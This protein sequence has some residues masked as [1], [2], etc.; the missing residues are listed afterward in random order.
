MSTADQVWSQ[1]TAALPFLK[2]DL[3]STLLES[4]F[5]SASALLAFIESHQ[6]SSYQVRMLS[7]G[8]RKLQGSAL[9]VLIAN[10][11]SQSKY[12]W[13]RVQESE[14]PDIL[15]GEYLIGSG[16]RLMTV[17]K[18][19]ARLRAWEELYTD[20]PDF[21]RE[22]MLDGLSSDIG[23]RISPLPTASHLGSVFWDDCLLRLK[24]LL[25][26]ISL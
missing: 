3:E 26:Q 5:E 24:V 16:S 14:D 8:S 1:A 15:H 13:V 12:S 9:D 10:I 21:G 11:S 25:G 22:R 18:S 19:L 2:E 23:P 7:R 20:S 17:K 6:Q 4:P